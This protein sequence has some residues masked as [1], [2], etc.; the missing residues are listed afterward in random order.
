MSLHFSD[1]LDSA[2]FTVCGI[3]SLTGYLRETCLWI[4]TNLPLYKKGCFSAPQTKLNYGQSVQETTNARIF[5]EGPH[6]CVPGFEYIPWLASCGF[7]D[8]FERKFEQTLLAINSLSPLG[9]WNNYLGAASKKL[10][11]NIKIKSKW[12][13]MIHLKKNIFI[14]A[15][16]PYIT[17]VENLAFQKP[18]RQRSTC[19]GGNSS[20]A[21]DGNVSTNFNPG[22]QCA[23][24]QDD[25]PSWWWVN[26]G[27]DNVPISEVLIV[28]RFSPPEDGIRG[29]NEDYIIT[30]G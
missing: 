6:P 29:R 10:L 28:N 23:H 18:T 21:V 8:Q 30:L 11:A 14:W 22:A 20:K 16:S 24:T 27:S 17:C 13:L 25:N 19:C 9:A 26:L 12:R 4:S 7:A 3:W 15:L 2:F 1:I 5:V